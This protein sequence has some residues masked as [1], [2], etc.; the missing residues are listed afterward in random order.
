MVQIIRCLLCSSKL[1]Y[2]KIYPVSKDPLDASTVEYDAYLKKKRTA[3]SQRTHVSSFA[4]NLAFRGF[5]RLKSGCS[6]VFKSNI[7]LIES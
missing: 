2:V 6:P 4:G 1:H 5:L 7:A 3:V